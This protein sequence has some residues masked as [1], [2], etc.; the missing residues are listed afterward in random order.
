MKKMLA[1]M[2]LA[3]VATA[4]SPPII[5]EAKVRLCDETNGSV[6]ITLFDPDT[7]RQNTAGKPQSDFAPTLIVECKCEKGFE[8]N[9]TT[10]CVNSKQ[11]AK[12]K[13]WEKIIAFIKK[14]FGGMI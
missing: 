6:N 7:I 2:L 12:A 10:G 1:L 4:F 3:T 11:I 8:W 14:L 13:F 9:E 5:D